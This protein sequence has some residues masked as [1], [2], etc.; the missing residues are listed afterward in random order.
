VGFALA[1]LSCCAMPLWAQV[2][3]G[4]ETQ[5]NLDGSISAGYGGSFAN[6]SPDSSGLVFGGTGNLSGSFHSPQFLS[7]DVA[8]FFN[9]SRNNS[10]YQSITDASGVTATANFFGG[11]Q[12][13][14]FVNFS[15]IYNSES[16]YSVPGLANYATNGN[17]QTLGIGWSA[18][19]KNAPSFTFGYQQGS[20]D[21]SLY[22][23]QQDTT[24]NF[25]SLFGSADYTVDGF[26]LNGGIHHS[27]TSSL[28]PEII[29]G[30]SPEQASSDTT[31]YTFNVTRTLPLQGSMWTNFTRSTT[32][33]DTLGL[34]SSES[35]D[36]WTG[37][38]ALK[39]TNKLT[40]QFSADYDDNLAGSIFQSVTTAGAVAP[41]SITEE[42]SHSW[43]M[44]GQAQYSLI[45]GLYLTG[46]VGYRQQLFL[47]VSYDSTVFG[48]SVSYG[49]D[50]LGGQ[51]TAAATV[52]HNSYGNNGG[53]M[54][55]FLSNVI[56]IRRFGAWG[57]SG[58]F[59]YSQNVQS[60]LI[61]YTTSG[62]SYSGSANRRIGRLNLTLG[63]SGAKSLLSQ[64]QGPTTFTQGYTAGLSGRWLGGS[65][66]YSRS[67]GNGLITPAGVTPLPPGVPPTLLSSVLYGGTTY[68]ASVGSTPKRGF[69]L[70]GSYVKSRSNTLSGS[71]SSNNDTEEAYAYMSYQF[72][73]VYFNA[74]YS[75]LLQG[76][77]AAG[78]TPTTLSTY[79]FGVSRW[80]KAF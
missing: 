46:T 36:I 67:S 41:V 50:L 37:G 61:A 10:G 71:L 38:V 51:F 20:T 55:G 2:Q 78:L 30:E 77:S 43:G 45:Q 8:P 54:L 6:N 63:A 16:N 22:G 21:Y 12:F 65:F 75:R 72:R 70:N 11:S 35:T 34:S 31:T 4:S 29:S 28:Y 52:T 5:L 53:S 25:H 62:Y 19:F 23:I 68:S 66:G 69:I 59:G 79:Y 73:K 49:H 76:F 39:V 27:T 40:T 58:S 15:K 44:V 14:G 9:Q 64:V 74:G 24:S 32:G 7:F 13:P 1:A 48:G 18:N 56:Y 26:H 33:Y 60:L 42:P 47:G 80:F 3:V 17:D 57:V